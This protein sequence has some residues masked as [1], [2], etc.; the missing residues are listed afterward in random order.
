MNGWRPRRRRLRPA[1]CSGTCWPSPVSVLRSRGFA[2]LEEAEEDA[3]AGHAPIAL[4]AERRQLVDRTI[5]R[6]RLSLCSRCGAC[7]T[8][9]SRSLPI[10]FL[11]RDAYI[12]NYRTEAFM[13][14]ERYSYFRL[15]PD[16]SLACATCVDQTCLCPQGLDVP[17]ALARVHAQ[18]LT[19]AAKGHRPGHPA[20]ETAAPNAA[21]AVRVLS[22]E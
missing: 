1:T 11:F 20:S 12:W 4:S 17:K 14:D 18:V 9:C 13:A 15:H 2:S 5:A 21:H 7:D 16:T 19:L 3:R 22:H 10:S 6:M 8:A